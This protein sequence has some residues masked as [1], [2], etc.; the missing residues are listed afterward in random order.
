MNFHDMNPPKIKDNKKEF[1][2][3]ID[4]ATIFVKEGNKKPVIFDI[5]D[6]TIKINIVSS[7]GKMNG[8]IDIE[9]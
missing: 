2:D 1:L 6:G 3:T 8:E 9:K 4:S 5:E 7:I